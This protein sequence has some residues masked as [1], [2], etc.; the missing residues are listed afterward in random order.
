MYIFFLFAVICPSGSECAEHYN[1]K[2]TLTWV[3]LREAAADSDSS[4]AAA[5]SSR[6]W[7][8]AP[9]SPLHHGMALCP[10]C[11]VTGTRMNGGKGQTHGHQLGSQEPAHIITHNRSLSE[12]GSQEPVPGTA[13]VGVAKTDG[14]PQQDISSRDLKTSWSP[15]R[16][17]ETVVRRL[18]WECYDAAVDDKNSREKNNSCAKSEGTACRKV[19][20]WVCGVTFTRSVKDM[21]KL[22]QTK[23]SVSEPEEVTDGR[24]L[25]RSSGMSSTKKHFPLKIIYL[26]NSS[27]VLF[28]SF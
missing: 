15:C 13:S 8:A 28:F 23:V 12:G 22:R 5:E 27:H 19:F 21:E 26:C 16:H 18:M 7:K 10:R 25:S 17:T 1:F 24:R 14:H 9:W 4:S 3:V 2:Y 20:I 11:G 6:P